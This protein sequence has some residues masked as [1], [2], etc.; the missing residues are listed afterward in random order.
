[1]LIAFSHTFYTVVFLKLNN[2]ESGFLKMGEF[3]PGR[4]FLE[5]WGIS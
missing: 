3:L 4:K 5:C 2:E 1:M